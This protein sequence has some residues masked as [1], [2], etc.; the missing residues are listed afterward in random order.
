MY[1][2]IYFYINEIGVF[3]SIVTLKLMIWETAMF[4]VRMKM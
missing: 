3:F 1:V 2:K 4:Y